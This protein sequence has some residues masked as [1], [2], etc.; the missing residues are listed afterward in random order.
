MLHI[1][2]SLVLIA[3]AAVI[4][5]PIC[6]VCSSFGFTGVATLVGAGLMMSIIPGN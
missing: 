6:A 2:G 5:I 1:I 3:T 4:A